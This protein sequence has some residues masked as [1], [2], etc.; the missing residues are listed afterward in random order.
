MGGG[1]EKRKLPSLLLKMIKMQG[2]ELD[3][4]LHRTWPGA[5]ATASVGQEHAGFGVSVVPA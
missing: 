4:T 3:L 2:H 5:T 1:E